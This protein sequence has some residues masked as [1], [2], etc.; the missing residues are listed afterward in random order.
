MGNKIFNFI[1][2]LNLPPYLSLSNPF[3]V[4]IYSLYL[5]KVSL[6]LSDVQ[7]LYPLFRSIFPKI[8]RQWK[9]NGDWYVCLTVETKKEFLVS[10]FMGKF[11]SIY[12]PNWPSEICQDLNLFQFPIRKKERPDVYYLSCLYPTL[13]LLSLL[14]D[15]IIL[16]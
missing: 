14:K 9:S 15:F 1:N 11:Y 2:L 16:A 5:P 6:P 4:P 10:H 3:S 13:W 12:Y 7:S 8:K